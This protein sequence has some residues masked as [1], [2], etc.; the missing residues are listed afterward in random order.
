VLQQCDEMQMRTSRAYGVQEQVQEQEQEQ[1]TEYGV[2][3]RVE[4]RCALAGTA[5]PFRGTSIFF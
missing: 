3:V 4:R 1:E 2:Q 5:I